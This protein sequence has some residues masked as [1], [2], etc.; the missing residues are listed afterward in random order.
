MRV[1]TTPNIGLNQIESKFCLTLNSRDKLKDG[2]YSN[3]G[4]IL[5]DISINFEQKTVALEKSVLL[6]LINI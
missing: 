2:K 4:N 6:T 1:V 3:A 5:L